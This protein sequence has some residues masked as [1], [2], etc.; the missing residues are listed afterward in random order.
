MPLSDRRASLALLCLALLCTSGTT[1]AAN[2][3]LLSADGGSA[4]PEAD[5]ATASGN[6]RLDDPQGDATG[7][8]AVRRT[9]KAKP[10]ATPRAAGNRPVAPR[11]HSFLPGMF[12]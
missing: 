10:A 6:E 7:A 12:R 4:C 5:P 9:P 3:R 2:G 11:W 8:A 1:L